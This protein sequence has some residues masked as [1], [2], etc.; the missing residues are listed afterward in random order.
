MFQSIGFLH[1]HKYFQIVTIILFP[2]QN[3]STKKKI[4]FRQICKILIQ[5]NRKKKKKNETV[6]GCNPFKTTTRKKNCSL[7]IMFAFHLKI[8][9][10]VMNSTHPF[11]C[12][13][14][15]VRDA[16]I[17]FCYFNFLW[18]TYYKHFSSIITGTNFTQSFDTSCNGSSV[19]L[20]VLLEKI[21]LMKRN[22]LSSATF[23]IR[24]SKIYAQCLNEA[25]KICCR[26]KKRKINLK[27]RETKKGV[28]V[29]KIQ[30]IY[31][32]H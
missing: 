12:Q 30:R 17:H 28:G 15:N 26:R 10:R 32:H 27:F 6:S 22:C 24:E 16:D 20:V 25:K 8:L 29:L 9:K 21:K 18:S 5:L 23:C 1:W 11:L 13:Y 7:I 3:R 14:W 31:R 2:F 19:G 4:K